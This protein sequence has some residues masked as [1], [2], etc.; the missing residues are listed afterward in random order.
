MYYSYVDAVQKS[1]MKIFLKENV[2]DA[3][4]ERIRFLF[5]E[6]PNVVVSFSG[7]KDSTVILEIALQVAR[8][9]NRLPLTVMWLDQ[10]AEW[11]SVV[12]YTK[13]VMYRKEVNPHWLQVPI[14][15][16]NATTMDYP[17]LNCWDLQEEHMREKD[18][19][20]I[21]ENVYGTDRF[22]GMFPK[23]LAHHFKGEPVALLGGVRAEESPNRRAGLTNGAT[24]KDITY[25]KVY[26]Q[27]QKHYVFYPLYDWSY[28]DIWKAIHDHKWNY[29]KIYD[30]FYRYGIP[31]M[32]MRVSNLHHETAVDQLFYLHELEGDTW[33]KL[34][35]RLKG[36]NQAKHLTKAD[37]FKAQD[38]P[39]MFKDWR[40]YR[41]HLCEN[42]IQDKS[43]RKKLEKKHLWM[44]KKFHDMDNIHE[45][46][47]SQILGILANDFEFTKIGN[48]LGRPETINF[49]K[50]KRGKPINWSR[51]ERDLRYI[52]KEQRLANA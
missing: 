12:D 23:Y 16:F 11:Q 21:K 48:F 6:F 19:I 28:I 7:G 49:L 35:K 4:V 33:N 36:I 24:Y 50:F 32:K 51:P 14:K 40:D 52:K 47:K 39:F 15:L 25:G 34:T 18:K 20:S 37:M 41:D 26:D 29:C 45:M 2:Y 10:E 5:E 38:L 43:I 8:D 31:P 44:D 42:L 17:W 13:E 30:Q 22:F 1:K 9:M 27:K 46:Y 3:A